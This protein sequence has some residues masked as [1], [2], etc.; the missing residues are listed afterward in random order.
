MKRS[1]ALEAIKDLVHDELVVTTAGGATVEWHAIHPSDGNLQAKTLGLCSSIGLG[2]ALGLEH[3]KFE[4]LVVVEGDGSLL[5]G[6]SALS[7]IG[8]LGPRKLLLIVLD[9]GT[10]A[11]TGGQPT[12]ADKTDFAAVARAC[13]FDGR[14]VD[15]A[16]ALERGLEA[17]RRVPGPLLLRVRI[18]PQNLKTGYF[19]EDPVVLCHA[20]AEFLKRHGPGG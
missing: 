17:A 1:E 10:Y 15:G 8:R 3:S 2:L 18:G 7:T 20:F 4:K 19:L 5:M 9:N 14:D 12:G 11:A 13:G 16:D 6:F